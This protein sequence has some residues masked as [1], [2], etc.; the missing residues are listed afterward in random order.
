MLC[1]L[2]MFVVCYCSGQDLLKGNDLSQVKADQL[3]DADIARFYKQLQA[4][5][6]TIAQAEQLAVAKGMPSAEVAKLKQ[7]IQLLPSGGAGNSGGNSISTN[8]NT[9]RS[10][11]GDSDAG[12]EVAGAD[13]LGQKDPEIFGA[14]LFIK[15]I[16][17]SQANFQMATPLNYEL[18]PGDEL[19]I[20]VF[21][22]QEMTLN[23]EITAEGMVVIPNV[24]RLKVAGSTIEVATLRIRKAMED[25]AYPTLKSGKS[26]LDVTLGGKIRSIHV[27]IIG[28]NKPGTYT[29]SSLATTFNALYISGGPSSYGSFREIELIRDHKVERK[30]DLYHFLSKGDQQDNIRLRDN[31]VIRIPSYKKRVEL[32]GQVKRQGIFELLDGENF[33][34]LLEFASGFTDTAYKA[35]I[36]VTQ[37][38]EAERKVK[39]IT[40]ASYLA[41]VPLGGDIIYVSEILN[42]FQNRV[43]ISGAVFRPGYFELTEGMTVADLIRRADGLKEDAFTERAQLV[44]L[45]S[46]LTKEIIPF[47]VKDVLENNSAQI[48]LKKEDEV[49]IT[50]IFDLK[51]EFKVTIQ[52]EIR[53]PGEYMYIDSLSLKD[54][55][56]LAGGFTDAAK[57]QKIEISRM[58]IRDTLTSI[59][60]RASEMIE[61][62]SVQDLANSAGNIQLHPFDVITVRRKPGYSPLESVV[63]AGQVQY[64]GPYVI[65]RRSERI[66]DLIKRS[67]SFTPEAY[68]E[69]AYLKRHLTESEIVLKK[70]RISRLQE[71]M[72]DT[73]AK[74][75]QDFERKYDQI[76]LELEVIMKNPG[77]AGDLI[78]KAGD[79]L[80]IPKFDAQ[81]RISGGV[82]LPT[83]IPFR[84]G[85]K[86]NDYLS[87]AGGVSQDALKRKIYVLYANGKAASTMHFL[88]FKRFP[89]V[90]PGSEIIVPKKLPK[91]PRNSTETIGL[92]SVFAS[93]A[94]VIIAIINVT[95]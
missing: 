73:S 51:D 47:S 56:V 15:P 33:S 44:R 5:G 2:L 60:E 74:I 29:L 7:R 12:N 9:D 23:T 79:V 16:L 57:S 50:S 28:A 84:M 64:P 81:I 95:K 90:K 85:Y 48:A 87:A 93:L 24:G 26:K 38:T 34:S 3:S 17:S 42:R 54:L 8:G 61:I 39:D 82:L 30:I 67:G 92:A 78:V 49:V 40:A 19:Q 11:N 58:L 32:R 13:G 35:S 88:F 20:A 91:P 21:G 65:S 14:E 18:G 72:L 22:V 10:L 53:V 76:P 70:E 66:S 83:Q 80:Y 36:K 63:V 46:D 68:I 41:Y 55:I 25:I 37:L 86:V 77:A 43:N 62:N 1:T 89:K 45:K 31:D 59:D 27:T 75:L 52:G 71:N 4:S 69:G 94:G 6:L